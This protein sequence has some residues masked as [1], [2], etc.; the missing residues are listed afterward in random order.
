M[1]F[2]KAALAWSILLVAMPG[3]RA[4][5]SPEGLP[6]VIL[7]ADPIYPPLARQTGSDGDGRVKFT[8]DGESVVDLLVES[9]HPR[10]RPAAEDNVRTWKFVAHTLAPST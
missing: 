9:R 5:T 1:R 8:T 10:L 2:A 7:H 3:A 4:Q 6:K